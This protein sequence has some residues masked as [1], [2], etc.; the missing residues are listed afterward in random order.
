M[1]YL[2]VSLKHLLFILLFLLLTGAVI[3]Y[4]IPESPLPEGMPIDKLVINKSKR[5]LIAYS[6]QRVVK[7][8]FIS[9]GRNPSGD[10]KFQ[11]DSKT[12]EGRYF[13][14]SKNPNGDYFMN[15]GI[16]YPDRNDRIYAKRSGKN[17]GGDI[18]IH[19]LKNGFGFLRKFHRFTDWT[20]GCIGLT[21]KEI[22]ELYEAVNIGT[23]IQIN[24]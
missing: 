5:E 10:K 20:N 23:V 11:G 16:S 17:P 3:Y 4:F 9:L 8:Y 13:I 2:K 1:S 19:G 18:K 6:N 22:E 12:P 7:R 24:P 15:L 14:D 21:N